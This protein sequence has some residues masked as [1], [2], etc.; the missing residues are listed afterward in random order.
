MLKI[1][2]ILLSFIVIQPCFAAI[3]Y[4]RALVSLMKLDDVGAVT[5]FLDEHPGLENTR[6]HEGNNL[7]FYF[8]KHKRLDLLLAMPD[9]VGLVQHQNNNEETVLHCLARHNSYAELHELLVFIKAGAPE[10]LPDLLALK[11]KSGDTALHLAAFFVAPESIVILRREGA[12]LDILNNHH[13]SPSD[14]IFRQ[15]ILPLVDRMQREDAF[16]DEMS[17]RLNLAYQCYAL[18]SD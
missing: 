13:R 1:F 4:A 11:N 2:L 7:A 16:S 10:A 8:L 9:V 5:K 3:D 12:L 17:A 14:R 18:L 6:D 15:I